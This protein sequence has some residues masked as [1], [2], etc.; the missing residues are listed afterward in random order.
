M[1]RIYIVL[2]LLLLTSCATVRP[3]K[4]VTTNQDGIAKEEKKVD[5]TLDQID[6]NEQGKK[7][8]TSTLAQGIQHSLNQVTNPPIQV[9]TAKSL[10]D[11]VVSIVG[12]PNVDE[13]KRIKATV[14][15]LNSAVEEERKKGQELLSKR[16]E[17]ISKLQQENAELNQKYDDQMWEMTDKAKEQA[18]IADQNKAA[19]DSMSG[20]FG[21][22]A[23]FW[24]LK[25]FVFSCLTFII[26]FG[27][28]FLILRVLSTLNPAAAAAFGIFNLIGTTILSMI[29]ALTP[30]AF[31]MA[32]FTS[33]DHVDEY[34]SPLTKIVDV[35]QEFREKYK[36]NPDR[37]FTLDELLKKFDK[38]MDSH[39]KSLIDN[40]LAELRWKR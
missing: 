22:N 16:D 28:I 12:S 33:K 9:E 27:I 35:I 34:K 8:Q 31:E 11:R 13:M 30:H 4:Q 1:K 24:G 3:A 32:N 10:N 39:E 40:L 14:D 2:S 17:I 38:E 26:V 25:K 15:L 20:M 37:T 29:K 36:E 5:K 7:S 19:L 23:V 21:L 18:K 6:K